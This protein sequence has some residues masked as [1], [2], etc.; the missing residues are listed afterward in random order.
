[1]K[2]EEIK[3]LLWEYRDGELDP[4]QRA[5]VSAHAAACPE[6][7][8]LLEKMQSLSCSVR[9]ELS[10]PCAGQ[11][12]D[13]V[14]AKLRTRQTDPARRLFPRVDAARHFF[15]SLLFHPARLAAA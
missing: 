15:H 13:S 3:A 1:M 14:L 7:A 12:A 6:C 11:L 2:H 10:R 9:Q 5:E 4:A 8:A